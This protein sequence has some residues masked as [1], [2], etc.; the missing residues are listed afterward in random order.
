VVKKRQEC[1]L[2]EPFL[3]QVQCGPLYG[4]H[5][6]IGGTYSCIFINFCPY[7]ETFCSTCFILLFGKN[8]HNTSLQGNKA[9][10]QMQEVK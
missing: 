9:A 1:S 5:A 4:K 7:D 2:F 8:K 3:G 6:K 10:S